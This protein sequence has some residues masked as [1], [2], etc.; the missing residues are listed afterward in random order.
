[1][2]NNNNFEVAL[3]TKS[4]SKNSIDNILIET[5]VKGLIYRSEV[6]MNDHLIDAMEVNCS[7]ISTIDKYEEI[8]KA[9]YAANHSKLKDKYT[10]EKIFSKVSTTDGDYIDGEGAIN[11]ITSISDKT[12]KVEAF[13]DSNPL[14]ISQ[15][16]VSDGDEKVFKAKYT[17]A[18]KDFVKKYMAILRFP[19]NTFIN[20][21]IKKFPFYKKSPMTAFMFFLATIALVIWIIS[22]II[23]GKALKKI[24]KAVAGKEAALVVKD[25]QKTM[26]KKSA[27][28]D[29]AL[30]LLLDENGKLVNNDALS[31]L[32]VIPKD[33]KFKTDNRIYTVYIKNNKLND[34]LIVLRDRVIY[35]F[36]NALVDPNMVINVLNKEAVHIKAGK[37]GHFEFKLESSFLQSDN[38]EEI[39]Y[40]GTIVLDVSDLRTR[41]VTPLVVGFEFSVNRDEVENPGVEP[42]SDVKVTTVE[43]TQETK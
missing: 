31:D 29:D 23:C 22:I 2:Q 12:Y 16:D 21:V 43:D 40:N 15:E 35:N 11:I 24:V 41:K 4:K 17:Q 33:I 5:S 25:L 7:D 8:F 20:P 32:V 9:R 10:Q 38:I 42:V 39:A 30:T 27:D 3:T 34:V 28:E 13:L 6:F 1:M 14:D 19:A 18:H 26:C 36:E 37:V